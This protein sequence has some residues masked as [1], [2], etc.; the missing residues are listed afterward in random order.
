LNDPQTPAPHVVA[1]FRTCLGVPRHFRNDPEFVHDALLSIGAAH[2]RLLDLM[3][4]IANEDPFAA[5]RLL[6]TCGINMFGHVLSAYPPSWYNT[7]PGGG[8]TPSQP[9]LPPYSRQLW[10]KTSLTHYLRGR[11]ERALLPWKLTQF[12]ATSERFFG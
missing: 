9:L 10:R 7:L 6:H 3:E 2:D 8:T 5:L 4:E 11:E 12:A 1:G